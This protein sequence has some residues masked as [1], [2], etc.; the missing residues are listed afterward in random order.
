ALALAWIRDLRN[1]LARKRKVVILGRRQLAVLR[2]L[3]IHGCSHD[4]FGQR[5]SAQNARAWE[6]LRTN[7]SGSDPEG[8]P[9]LDGPVAK[10]D[11]PTH[12]TTAHATRGSPISGRRSRRLRPS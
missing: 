12:R 6:S 5:Q 2:K 11:R 1:A 4:L 3:I 8:I 10:L 7:L 9:F